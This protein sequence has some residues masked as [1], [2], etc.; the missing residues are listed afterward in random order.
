[1][2]RT[3][4]LKSGLMVSRFLGCMR[5]YRTCASKIIGAHCRLRKLGLATRLCTTAALCPVLTTPTRANHSVRQPSPPVLRNRRKLLS[6][7]QVPQCQPQPQ[8]L[9]SLASRR[10]SK[11]R[12]YHTESRPSKTFSLIHLPPSYNLAIRL[13]L[14]LLSF[15]VKFEN[16][17][18]TVKATSD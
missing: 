13:L 2:S 15:R 14:S 9:P 3:L 6:C 5:A 16:S 8:L 11:L 10:S 17:R 7:L 12:S 1:M 18:K 4:F